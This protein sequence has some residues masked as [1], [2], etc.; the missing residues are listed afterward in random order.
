MAVPA[1]AKTERPATRAHPNIVLIVTDQWRQQDLG[2]TGN[3]QVRTP[4]IDALK[5]QSV[6]FAMAVANTPVCAPTRASLLT[7]RYATQTGVFYNDRPL[8]Q[9]A[10]TLAEV[11]R[12]AGYRTALIGKWHLDGSKNI[13]D[14]DHAIPAERRQGFE[15]WRAGEAT[16]DYWNSVYYDEAN[17]RRVWPGYDAAAQTAAAADYI[18]A[19]RARPFFLMLSLGPPHDPYDTAPPADKAAYA[20]LPVKLRPNVPAHLREAATKELRG[21]YAHIAALDRLIGDLDRAVV[22]NGIARD[23]IFVFT[24]DHGDMLRSQGEELK[25]KPWDESIRVPFLLRYPAQLKPRTVGQPFSSPDVMPTLLDLAGVPVPKTVSGLSFADA[26]R[27]GTRVA[28]PGALLMLPTPF[29]NWNFKA[30]GRAYRGIRTE[31]YTYAAD[32]TGPWLLYDNRRDPYQLNNL[33]RNPRYAKVQARL[34]TDTAA[35]TARI[36]DDFSAPQCYMD[37]WRLTWNKADAPTG[38]ADAVCPT[39]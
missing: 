31:R 20:K 17:T 23:T 11:L 39:R 33:A 21:Y 5:R 34:A 6:D 12:G 1:A 32:R 18:T 25:Q 27:S 28:T 30:G 16:H 29:G 26:A 9:D 7:G 37:R 13:A 8:P 35:L 24:S 36:G 14:R 22:A 2:Y 10:V 19:N 3:R 15:T 4:N 38:P